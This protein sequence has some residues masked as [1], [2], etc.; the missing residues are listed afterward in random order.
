MP[1]LTINNRN[2]EVPEGTS[3]LQACEQLGIEIP[4]FCYHEKLKVAGSC[5]MCLVEVE[6]MPKLVASCAQPCED[7][8]VVHTNSPAVKKTRQGAIEMLLINHPL[9]CLVCDQGG[10][11]D[12]QDMAMA[13]GRDRSR[14]NEEKRSVADEELGPLIEAA[15]TRCIH[16]TRCIRFTDEI[17]GTSELGGL[18]R[19]EKLEIGAFTDRPLTSELSGNLADVCPVGALTNKPASFR[20][21]SWELQK[22]DSIDVLDA[23]GCNI[24]IDTRGGEVMR[25]LP[26]R[27]D[28]INEIWIN[29][30]TRYACDGLKAQRLGRPYI[31]VDGAFRPADWDEALQLIASRMDNAPAERIAALAGDLADCESMFALKA[32]MKALD[33]PHLDCRQDGAT[34][35]VSARAGTIMNSG[36][37]GIER[38]DALL[39]IGTNPRHEATL[40]NARIRKSWRRGGLHIGL[41]GAAVDLTYPYEHVGVSPTA[42]RDVIE[43]KHAFA[44]TLQ[45]ARNPMVIVGAG[46][47]A[48]PDGAAIHALARGL[49]ET[50]DMIRLDWNGFNVLQ[51]AASRVGGLDLGFL[52]QANGLGTNGILQA[53][54]EGRMDIVYLLGADEI[55]MARLGNAFVIYQGHHGDKGA[56]NA[57]VILPGAAYTEKDALY[58]NT[59]GR[60][61]CAN[62]AVPPPGTAH[63][64]WQIIR[65]LSEAAGMTLPFDNLLALRA[66]MIEAC[67]PIGAMGQAGGT[68]WKTFGKPGKLSP[69]PFTP[70]IANFYMT[71]PISRASKTMAQCTAEILPLIGKGEV[72]HA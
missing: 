4:R 69:R 1:K 62:R 65:I 39:L 35:D 23:V 44:K 32:L 2:I 17:A 63:E 72:D 43:G 49:A 41:I 10:E 25:I 57:D 56:Q 15:M 14:Y 34:Y 21:R 68:A 46:A 54:E 22:T 16:C 37:A 27:N 20:A 13:Y 5:R 53:A 24:R 47:L 67:P 12:L 8:M 36:I 29:D 61:Q 40:V 3:L 6:K 30:K 42:I 52:P 70:T 45:N 7:G 18:F 51:L 11:C 66:Q 48:R 9:D 60:P 58:V 19:G 64:D 26:R 31:R 38:A 59:E 28:D 50:F 33:A 71:D 55:D